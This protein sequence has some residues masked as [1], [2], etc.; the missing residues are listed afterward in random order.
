MLDDS[1]FNPVRDAQPIDLSEVNI[2]E[3]K[4]EL[5]SCR[6]VEPDIP[7]PDIEI[8]VAALAAGDEEIPIQNT[9]DPEQPADRYEL[10]FSGFSEEKKAELRLW[11]TE[12]GHKVR[13]SVTNKLTH[14]FCGPCYHNN[15]RKGYGAAK[16]RKAR[17]IHA[18]IINK[19]DHLSEDE[20]KEILTSEE[21]QCT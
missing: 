11:A 4:N 15:P 5:Y 19:F 6:Q 1:N 13:C 12:A 10:Y 2:P 20:W 8:T 21:F 7:I 9:Q 14:M 17:E 3:V 18:T 16:L